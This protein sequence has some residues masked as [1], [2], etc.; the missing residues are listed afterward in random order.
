MLGP[1]GSLPQSFAAAAALAGLCPAHLVPA[2]AA[3]AVGKMA[4]LQ[5]LPS[6]RL[7]PPFPIVLLDLAAQYHGQT[8]GLLLLRPQL[9]HHT[10]WRQLGAAGAC[11]CRRAPQLP[12]SPLQPRPVQCCCAAVAALSLAALCFSIQGWTAATRSTQTQGPCPPA[13]APLPPGP[14]AAMRVSPALFRHRT[15]VMAGA[16]AEAAL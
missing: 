6:G 1:S 9:G 3:A 12:P 2:V 13:G 4:G 14:A 5:A 11:C 16:A 8:W 10:P 15:A 7:L